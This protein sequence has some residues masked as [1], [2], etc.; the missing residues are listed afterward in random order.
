MNTSEKPTSREGYIT[1]PD[2]ARCGNCGSPKDL[3]GLLIKETI[4]GLQVDT[5]RISCR[6]CYDFSIKYGRL[7]KSEDCI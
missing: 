5:M 4:K 1:L 6:K 7:P 2:N 3:M